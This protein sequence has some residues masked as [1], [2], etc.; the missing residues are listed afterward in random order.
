MPTPRAYISRAGLVA[1][2]N[3]DG[4]GWHLRRSYFRTISHHMYNKN[5]TAAHSMAT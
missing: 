2:S 1:C 3:F 4:A 5:L